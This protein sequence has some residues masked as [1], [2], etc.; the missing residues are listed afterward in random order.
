[1]KIFQQAV[2]KATFM[3]NERTDGSSFNMKK[4]ADTMEVHGYADTWGVDRYFRDKLNVIDIIVAQQENF[5]PAVK[6]LLSNF[7]SSYPD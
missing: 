1:M 6:T 7:V 3:S 4:I 2:I 5:Q